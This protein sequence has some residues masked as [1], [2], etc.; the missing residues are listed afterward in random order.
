[1]RKNAL[2]MVALLVVTFLMSASP[3]SGDQPKPTKPQI[4]S[5]DAL[6]LCTALIAW[7]I[8]H[9][10]EGEY[11]EKGKAPQVDLAGAKHYSKSDLEAMLIPS[12]V[13][14][15]SARDPWGNSYEILRNR[16]SKQPWSW[17]VRSLG[18]D[19][20]FCSDSYLVPQPTWDRCDDIVRVDGELV[21]G[22]EA[23]QEK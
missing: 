9:P 15:I 20:Q 12:Y 4:A 7:N 10:P 13:A 8:D 21:A 11:L 18:P 1:M 14:T 19:G 22:P 3:D 23:L 2:L 16:D 6:A 5:R 17:A